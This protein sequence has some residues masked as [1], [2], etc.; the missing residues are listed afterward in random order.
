MPSAVPFD[1]ILIANRGEIAVRIMRACREMGIRTIAVYSAADS[2]ALHVRCADEAHPIGGASPR[3][4]Y[5]SIDKILSMAV[6]TKAEAIHPGYGFLSENPVFAE[7][8]HDRGIV[9]IGPTAGVLRSVG[10]KIA[11]RHSAERCGVPVVPGSIASLNG[12]TEAAEIART[13][14]YPV[15]LKAAAGGGGKGMRMAHD[16]AE[17]RQALEVAAREA[18]RAFGDP[19]LY[20]EKLVDPAR[21]VEVQLLCDSFGNVVHLGERDCSI[22]RRFQKVIE[23]SP[24]P[25]VSDDLRSR[26]TTAAITLAKAIGYRNAGTVEFLVEGDRF[27][28]IEVNARLQVEHPVT[29]MVTGVDL[30]KEQIMVAGGSHLSITQEEVVCRGAALQARIYAENPDRNFLPS[31]GVI[32]SVI[33]PSGPGIRIDSGIEKGS[34]V[35]IEYD[36]LLSKLVVWGNTRAEA[37]ARMRQALQEYEISGV[38]TTLPFKKYVLECREFQS[39]QYDTGFVASVMKDW[40][41]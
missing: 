25:A 20:V 41:R 32:S 9:F 30:V 39:G 36:G 18:D 40:K 2:D 31:P 27:Y 8:C 12:H 28:F 13:I 33:E 10:N 19:S 15:L 16:E 23:E 29:E 24:S 5:L 37:V 34:T 7:A 22:Q 11:A 6:Q 35:P 14:G 1:R 4:S 38:H 21:H 17:L 26:I 3:E